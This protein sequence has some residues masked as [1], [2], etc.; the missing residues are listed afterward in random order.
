MAN[1]PLAAIIRQVPVELID[2]NTNLD[3]TGIG[4]G[5]FLIASA[6]DRSDVRIARNDAYVRAPIPYL[7]AM[8]WRVFDDD[9]AKVEAF[10]RREIDVMRNRD[11]NAAQAVR[12]K[13]GV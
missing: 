12:A 2:A 9:G 10:K 11:K 1:Q 4:S 5:P 13:T 6:D 7:D 8:A 3:A